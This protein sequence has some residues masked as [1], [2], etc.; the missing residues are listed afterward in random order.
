MKK[1]TAEGRFSD[2]RTVNEFDT[3]PR[4]SVTL[5]N[6]HRA[7]RRRTNCSL[8]ND[9]RNNG[10]REHFPCVC[11]DWFVKF[12]TEI[13]IVNL[14]VRRCPVGSL[15][16]SGRSV[17]TCTNIVSNVYLGMLV[18]F[19]L[20]HDRYRASLYIC[21]TGLSSCVSFYPVEFVILRFPWSFVQRVFVEALISHGHCEYRETHRRF[22]P[23]ERHVSV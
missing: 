17:S 6:E 1:K 22:L 16:R 3:I 23:S 10:R 13:L 14:S 2:F 21:P 12:S 7:V 5:S 19:V 9:I 15:E 18:S 4:S 11:L 20:H 8:R